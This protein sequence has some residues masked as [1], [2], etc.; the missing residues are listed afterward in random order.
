MNQVSIFFNWSIFGKTQDYASTSLLIL[1]RPKSES[2]SVSKVKT[3]L[4]VKSWGSGAHQKKCGVS[5]YYILKK[6][7]RSALPN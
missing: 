5:V 7:F 1:T 3:H 6:T 2:F 4:K